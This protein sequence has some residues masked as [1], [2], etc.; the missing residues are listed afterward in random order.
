MSPSRLIAPRRTPAVKKSG[1]ISVWPRE[2]LAKGLGL[3]QDPVS[4]RSPSPSPAFT[5]PQGCMATN[6]PA[7][8]PL[9]GLEVLEMLG[10][11]LHPP[12]DTQDT[13]GCRWPL[14]PAQ[15]QCQTFAVPPLPPSDT[16]TPR[17]R[18]VNA[19]P[20]GGGCPS[21]ERG[22]HNTDLLRAHGVHP[23]HLQRVHLHLS[24][25]GVHVLD[26]GVSSRHGDGD[27]HVVVHALLSRRRLVLP[28]LAEY[29]ERGKRALPQRTWRWEAPRG[30]SRAPGVARASLPLGQRRDHPWQRA[31]GVGGSSASPWG[32]REGQGGI[33]C[34]ACSTA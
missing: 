28:R 32:Q 33:R 20:P 34:A 23:G 2:D 3:Q 19:E 17:A 14:A 8:S 18:E 5:A 9:Q 6:G 30:V 21:R 27:A 24:G 26:V 22:Q 16:G 25:H 12:K 7:A 10:T 31:G 29:T 13:S 11:S 15:W 1:G 4:D